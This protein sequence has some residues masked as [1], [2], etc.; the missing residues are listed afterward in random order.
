MLF[1][2][3]TAAGANLGLLYGMLMTHLRGA[4]REMPNLWPYLVQSAGTTVVGPPPL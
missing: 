1:D 2:G 3:E 4:Q